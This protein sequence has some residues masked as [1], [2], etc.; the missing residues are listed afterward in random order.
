[1]RGG[2]AVALL[3]LGGL[4]IGGTVLLRPVAPP[5]PQGAGQ[6][7]FP[8]LAAALPQAREI[9]VTGGGKATTLILKETPRGVVWGIA[10][11]GLYPAVPARLRELLA[12]LGELRLLEPRTADPALFARLGVDETAAQ[13][14]TA[15]LL[16]VKGDGGAVLAELLVGHRIQRSK[17]G[18]PEAVYVR[19][20]GERQ[21]WLAEGRLVADADPQAW[22]VREIV[23]IGRARIAS[24]VVQRGADRL[25]FARRGEALTLLDPPLGKLDQFH[26]DEMGRAL[27][28]LTLADVRPGALPGAAL[29]RAVFTTVDGLVMTVTVNRDDSA[30]PAAIWASFAAGGEVTAAYGGLAGWAFQ[31]PAWRET[32]LVPRPSDMVEAEAAK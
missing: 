21:S 30:T 8:G 20:P 26:V 2:L 18:L 22:L 28:G 19:R 23:D 12:G 4:A 32:S 6:P 3:L 9:D 14:S 15:V 5:V 31:L 1:M 25:A 13:G 29:G 24:V 11:R 17:G 7:M 27:E 16:R 10:E